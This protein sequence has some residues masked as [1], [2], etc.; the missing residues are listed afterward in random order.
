MKRERSQS[1][2]ALVGPTYVESLESN[3]PEVPRLLAEAGISIITWHQLEAGDVSAADIEGVIVCGHA[4]V[5][6]ALLDRLPSLKV[7]SNYGVGVDHINRVACRQRGIPVGNTPDVLS[8]A[9]AD[10]AWALLMACAR[11]IV[12]GDALARSAAWTKYENM[13]APHVARTRQLADRTRPHATLLLVG[14]QCSSG[15]M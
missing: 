4:P 14:W 12:E 1:I 10:M 15:R 7:V 8:D 5:D 3:D 9:T 6:V 11:R 2:L 13:G